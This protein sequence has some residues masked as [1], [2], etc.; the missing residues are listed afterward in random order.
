[1]SKLLIKI[2]N[3]V[4]AEAQVLLGTKTKED[5]VN[6]ALLEVVERLPPSRSAG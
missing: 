5:T 4:L 2:N 1:M 6:A 3:E